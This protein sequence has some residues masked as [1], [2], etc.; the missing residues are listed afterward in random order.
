MAASQE[1]GSQLGPEHDPKSPL[2]Q[3][4]Q[5]S[6]KP[7][8]GAAG[9]NGFG[10]HA[11]EIRSDAASDDDYSVGGQT[12]PYTLDG[13]PA[14]QPLQ[15]KLG[16][17]ARPKGI[18]PRRQAY[19]V[20]MFCLTASLLYADQNLMAPNLTAIARDFGFNDEQ[21]DKYLG[22][23]IAAAFYIVGAPAALLFGYLS[24]TV[25]RRN[26]LFAAVLLG[27][28]P[29][30]MTYFVTRYWQLLVLRLLTGIS[31]GGTFPLVFSLLGDLFEPS[32]RAAVAAVV[33]LAMGVGLALGQGI[34]GFVGS[35]IGWR[36]PFVI[37]AVPSVVL[38]TVMVFT[39][40]EPARGATE[41][42][43]QQQFEDGSGFVYSER[44][45]M[46]KA[47]HM[48][49]IPTNVLAILQGL[50]GCLPWGMLLTFLNDYLSQNKGLS[51]PVATA[52]IL[53]I[54]I[55]G[56]IGVVG[57]GIVG[58]M[59][60]NRRKWSMPIFIGF[61][62]VLGTPPLWVL[63]NAPVDHMVWLAFLMA[64][65]TGI[66]SSTVG[67]NLRAM[68]LNVNEPETR[69]MALALQT[70]LDDLGKGMGPA[71]VAV[72]I[73]HLGRTAAFNYSAAGWIPCGLLL[74]GA[75]LTL[76]KDEAAMQRRL[77]HVVSQLLLSAPPS[78]ADL[79]SL[80]R[81]QQ[82]TAALDE[83]FALSD[84]S[85][86]DG[87]GYGSRGG[88]SSGRGGLNGGAS[89]G[90]KSGSRHG[91]GGG[92]LRQ[93]G[94]SSALMHKLG[95]G[96]QLVGQG[97]G[98]DAEL[99]HRL[100]TITTDALGA[101]EPDEAALQQGTGQQDWQQQQQQ[102]QEV[103]EEDVIEERQDQSYCSRRSRPQCEAGGSVAVVARSS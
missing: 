101:E 88:R 90:K 4:A 16:R 50:F 46:R 43:L 47:W 37:V 12:P 82:H 44:I 102:Q 99:Q 66:M 35:S 29:C 48:M 6:D 81:S 70:M 26:L 24:D 9:T 75:A 65:F 84:G 14:S 56:A 40:E 54:G 97:V 57:G 30:I 76:E 91:A 45:T 25:N 15:K 80:A 51:V 86:S 22:G 96:Q 64:L 68:M 2:L 39:T 8:S 87:E 67:P 100:L 53:L 77:Q 41:H 74:L 5:P 7:Y 93:G 69:G 83:A 71:L 28:G 10:M 85:E 89:G 98:E 19:M 3:A 42:A 49:C 92:R 21:R 11:L 32:K 95:G 63:I 33:Q 73:T 103:G 52:V 60:Y 94:G 72:L 61:C 78:G 27:E 36:W 23:Y 34:A 31:L 55:G 18:T 13:P 1:H 62:T 20:A 38:A 58:Q 59:L 17:M 79:P